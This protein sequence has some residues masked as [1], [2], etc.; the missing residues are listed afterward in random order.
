MMVARRHARTENPTEADFLRLL[1]KRYSAPAWAFFSHVRNAAGFHANRTMDGLAMGLWPSRGLELLGFEVKINRADWRRELANPRK[2]EEAGYAFC[3]RWYL[4]TGKDVVQDGELP[5]TWGH[6]VQ[7]GTRLVE[8]VK[9]PRL[10]PTPIDRMFLAVLLRRLHEQQME[11]EELKAARREG[12]AE[13]KELG[14]AALERAENEA[15][16]LKRAISEFEAASDVHIGQWGTRRIGEAVRVVL[17]GKHLRYRGELERMAAVHERAAEGL[18]AELAQL[19]TAAP[20][21][22][23]QHAGTIHVALPPDGDDDA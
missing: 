7:R 17:Q 8:C 5:T 20:A 22:P 4:V 2:A 21:S 11:P 9:A 12:L 10:E 6:L 1:A 18:Y 15:R 16:G 14:A 13:G 3:D 23:G 19:E